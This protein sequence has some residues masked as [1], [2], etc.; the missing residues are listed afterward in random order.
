MHAGMLL[1]ADTPDDQLVLPAP[2]ATL[3]TTEERTE[4]KAKWYADRAKTWGWSAKKHHGDG[5]VQFRS[6]SGAGRVAP[7]RATAAS[8]SFKAPYRPSSDPPTATALVEQLDTWQRLAF[9]TSAWAR[10]YYA[11][12]S[13]VE[14]VFS[15]VKEHGALARGTCQA[16]GLA[17][18]TIAVLARV[19]IYN[20]RKSDSIGDDDDGEGDE[21][22]V[23]TLR[24]GSPQPPDPRLQPDKASTA[25]RAPP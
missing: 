21:E 18:N 16:F 5:R 15:R 2:P 25:L 20:L 1:S 6:P 7:K 17:A 11:G 9:G 22:D 4:W 19:V 3:A 12:R 10:A 24:G 14:N 8:G 23:P 13:A